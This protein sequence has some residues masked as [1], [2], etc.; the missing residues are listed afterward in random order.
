[1]KN[2]QHHAEYQQPNCAMQCSVHNVSS[3]MVSVL[4]AEIN[5]EVY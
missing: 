1:M 4:A 5:P 2:V 3:Y